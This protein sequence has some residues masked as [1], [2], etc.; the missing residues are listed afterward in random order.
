MT[1]EAFD[2]HMW[3]GS[4]TLN[5]ADFAANLVVTSLQLGPVT[6]GAEPRSII[7]RHAGVDIQLDV[8]GEVVQLSRLRTRRRNPVVSRR[9]AHVPLEPTL[10]AHIRHAQSSVDDRSAPA[11]GPRA[12]RSDQPHIPRQPASHLHRHRLTCTRPRPQLPE[13][14]DDIMDAHHA[15]RRHRPALIRRAS[16]PHANGGQVIA[17][18][19]VS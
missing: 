11:L 6:P 16:N 14:A 7:M 9:A 1:H 19:V 12:S 17:A 8:L 13:H 15:T 5:P 3:V 18:A 2:A 4:L 10:H